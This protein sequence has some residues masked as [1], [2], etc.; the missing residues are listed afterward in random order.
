MEIFNLK[1]E[2]R[3]V[4]FLSKHQFETPKEKDAILYSPRCNRYERCENQVIVILNQT[5]K[6]SNINARLMFEA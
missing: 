6:I 3:F 4:F 5:L 2:F 1:R